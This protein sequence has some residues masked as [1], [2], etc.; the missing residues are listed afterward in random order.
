MTVNQDQLQ[1]VTLS[2]LLVHGGAAMPHFWEPI[3]L[4]GAKCFKADLENLRIIGDSCQVRHIYMR[5]GNNE[6]VLELIQEYTQ[7]NLTVTQVHLVGEQVARMCFGN[8]LRKACNRYTVAGWPSSCLQ[9]ERCLIAASEVLDRTNQDLLDSN[10][11]VY[12][13]DMVVPS[14][15][16]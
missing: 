6:L 4:A 13:R 14:I 3:V 16:I 10:F 2:G 5:N 7:R 15:E 8:Q 9:M 11:Y 1:E 12:L